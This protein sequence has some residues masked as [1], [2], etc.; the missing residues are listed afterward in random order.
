[1][2]VAFLL[3]AIFGADFILEE[4]EGPSKSSTEMVAEGADPASETEAP[5]LEPEAS[6][7]T[8]DPASDQMSEISEG[9][10]SVPMSFKDRLESY[11]D[12][13][14]M[15]LPPGDKRLDVVVRYYPHEPDGDIVYRLADLGY[16]VHERTTTEGLDAVATNSLYY[17]D[18]VDVRD[19]QSVALFLVENGVVLRQIRESRY[20][21]DWKA[22]AIEVG[23][24]LEARS[25]PP[26]TVEGIEQFQK[27][28]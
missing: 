1:M 7:S 21:A 17:G 14:L 19:L 8:E 6:T 22:N 3:D 18:D 15:T 5:K 25:R 16:Y 26:I 28:D 11:R 2:F 12:S 24:S 27:V 20:H 4:G 23:A 9:G 10:T 13:I